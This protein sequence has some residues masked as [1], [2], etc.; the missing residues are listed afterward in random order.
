M[1]LTTYKPKYIKKVITTPEGVFLARFIITSEGS[2]E[3]FSLKAK[4]FE[5]IPINST[6]IPTSSEG[7]IY[8]DSGGLP[9]DI[10]EYIVRQTSVISP[11]ANF[12]FFFSQPTRAPSLL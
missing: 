10:F 11:Y 12:E 4:L 7:K 1:Q 8:L 6:A 5:L 3:G 9:N 2:S